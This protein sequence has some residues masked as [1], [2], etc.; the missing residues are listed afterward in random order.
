MAGKLKVETKTQKTHRFP[1]ASTKALTK[2]L[3][4]EPNAH[5]LTQLDSAYEL[6]SYR[7]RTHRVLQHR[8][9]TRCLDF[10]ETIGE[11]LVTCV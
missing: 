4:R 9:A 3:L 7:T 2:A 5:C 8:L 11:V 6:I 1:L 10:T